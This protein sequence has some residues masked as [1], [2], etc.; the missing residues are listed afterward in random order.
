MQRKVEI[1][2]NRVVFYTLDE[3]KNIYQI[4]DIIS[5]R[6]GIV[7]SY[8][9]TMGKNYEIG[10]YTVNESNTN[11]LFEID[12]NHPL[13]M[14][15]VDCLYDGKELI[16]DDDNTEKNNKKY[17]KLFMID[18]KI[19]LQ[20]VNNLTNDKSKLSYE[21]FNITVKNNMNS[22]VEK[23]GLDTKDR[24]YDFFTDVHSLMLGEELEK[25]KTY[26]KKRN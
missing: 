11:L 24:L 25:N 5:D 16:I 6:S 12:S 19:I 8:I 10:G 13:Y 23:K 21:K 9:F 15:F 7:K 22:K 26:V 18:D 17:L 3:E 20:F 1:N 4:R 2:K 14:S